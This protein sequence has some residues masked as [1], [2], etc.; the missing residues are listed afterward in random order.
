MD[1]GMARLGGW[2]GCKVGTV[3]RFEAGV[4]GSR[5]EV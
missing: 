4:K 3:E 5:P 1:E 2:K